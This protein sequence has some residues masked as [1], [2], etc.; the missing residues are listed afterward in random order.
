MSR[1]SIS[2]DDVKGIFKALQ[3]GRLK[4]IFETRTLSFLREMHNRYGSQFEMFCSFKAENYCFTDLGCQ[5]VEEFR[6]NANWLIWG[7]HCYDEM[8]VYGEY[9]GE[10]FHTLLS[11]INEC[12]EERTGQNKISECLRIHRFTGSREQCIELQQ[13]GVRYLFSSDDDR[14]NYYLNEKENRVLEKQKC[15][16]DSDTDITFLKSCIRLENVSEFVEIEDDIRRRIQLK[17]EII[18]VFTHE[19]KMD[20]DNIRSLFEKCCRLES[21]LH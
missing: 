12:I 6:E 19:C 16:Y 8:D 10:S 18:P 21:E 5:Y 1:I 15:L 17:Q 20:D 4:S 3:T 13:N 9:S 14:I 2:I 11:R 7:F